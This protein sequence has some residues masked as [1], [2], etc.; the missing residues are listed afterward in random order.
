MTDINWD[1][2]CFFCSTGD[3]ECV[4]YALDASNEFVTPETGHTSC[5]QPNFD[6]TCVQQTVPPFTNVCD[7]KLY[8]VWAGTDSQGNSFSSSGLRFS[9]YRAF[10]LGSLY[11]SALAGLDTGL[12]SHFHVA[13]GG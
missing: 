3:P 7:L 6:A 11:N 5:A 1:D 2:G 10:G 13:A 4:P 8:V 12:V 9:Q